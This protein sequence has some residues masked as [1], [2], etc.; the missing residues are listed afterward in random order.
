MRSALCALRSPIIKHGSRMI[1][2]FCSPPDLRVEEGT[3]DESRK[4]SKSQLCCASPLQGQ[5]VNSPQPLS[6][7]IFPPALLCF[8]RL[9][10]LASPCPAPPLRKTVLS[11]RKHLHPTPVGRHPPSAM[12]SGPRLHRPPAM[13]ATTTS[14]RRT[15]R[16]QRTRSPLK[17]ILLSRTNPTTSPVSDS[18]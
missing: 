2:S 14:K 8:L 1:I 5:Q 6:V 12:L 15:S 7:A 13:A 16:W 9:L 17:L 3:S 18:S 11:C 4:H 10:D